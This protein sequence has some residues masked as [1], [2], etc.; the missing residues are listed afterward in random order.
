MKLGYKVAEIKDAVYSQELEKYKQ[1]K[2]KNILENLLPGI[3]QSI[4]NIL[5]NDYVSLYIEWEDIHNECIVNIL[6]G[7]GTFD[8]SKSFNG[9]IKPIILNT[10]NQYKANSRVI[11]YPNAVSIM[12]SY[13]RSF[14]KECNTKENNITTLAQLILENTDAMNTLQN[15]AYKNKHH[16]REEIIELIKIA[17][18]PIISCELPTINSEREIASH[19]QGPEK[20]YEMQQLQIEMQKIIKT[21]SALEQAI[22]LIKLNEYTNQKCYNMLISR[23]PEITL[24]KVKTTWE[25]KFPQILSS[26]FQKAPLRTQ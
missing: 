6:N 10:I 19:Y 16:T 7:I 3:S 15:K 20:V 25:Q 5:R 12:V 8:C 2:N 17:I 23:F 26:H 18:H 1:E 13:I 4:L 9:Y 24:S 21:L 11:K 22:I 14:L